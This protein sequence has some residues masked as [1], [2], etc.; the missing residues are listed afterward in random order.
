MSCISLVCSTCPA[1]HAHSSRNQ[2]P[3]TL[4]TWA[5]YSRCQMPLFYDQILD[6][7]VPKQ[8]EKILIEWLV[9]TR[10]HEAIPII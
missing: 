1:L 6:D 8:W 4:S 5:Y 9:K 3:A 10:L 2:A 7:W